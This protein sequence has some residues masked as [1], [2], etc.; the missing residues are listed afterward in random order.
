[1]NFITFPIG[2]VITRWF[3]LRVQVW[4]LTLETHSWHLHVDRTLNMMHIKWWWW[5]WR[6]W[7]PVAS[8]ILIIIAS[9]RPQIQERERERRASKI[10]WIYWREGKNRST[11]QVTRCSRQWGHLCLWGTLKGQREWEREREREKGVHYPWCRWP[12]TIERMTQSDQSSSSA[13]S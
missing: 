9:S 12:I 6:W 11:D 7:P 5:W 2:R 3:V 10:N 13:P 8:L 1:M 4:E